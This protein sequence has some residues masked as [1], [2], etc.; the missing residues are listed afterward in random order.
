MR[1]KG[2][3]HVGPQVVIDTPTPQQAV[4]QPF[5]LGG[6]AADLD[7]PGGNGID[8][9][10]VWAYPVGSG[11]PVFVG[12][13]TSGLSRPDVAAVHGEQFRDSGYGLIVQGLAPGSYDLAVF[14]WSRVRGGFVPATLVRVTVQ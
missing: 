10:H 9:L 7:A 5:A 1:P 2:H 12:T 8:T 14:A 6:W 13:A 4:G 11:A 3:G